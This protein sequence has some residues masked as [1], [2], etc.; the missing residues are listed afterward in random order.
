MKNSILDEKITTQAEE[1]LESLTICHQDGDKALDDVHVVQDRAAADGA[2][3]VV[4]ALVADGASHRTRALA[5]P[6]AVLR[7]GRRVVVE[8]IRAHRT[9]RRPRVLPSVVA[10]RAV[11][12]HPLH[13]VA[14]IVAIG[15]RVQRMQYQL[16]VVG[17]ERLL[18]LQQVVTYS[19]PHAC[20]LNPLEYRSAAKHPAGRW[21]DSVRKL[22]HVLFQVVDGNLVEQF[23]SLDASKQSDLARS[24]GTSSERI[25]EELRSVN[26]LSWL[27][28]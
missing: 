15:D 5:R 23:L 22:R 21:K 26:S 25:I 2:Q 11:V 20:G 3:V 14:L 19:L 16:Y 8:Q 1:S 10:R 4:H 7:V 24:I 6:H 12:R 18:A 13:D 27:F 28:C 9:R 17:A